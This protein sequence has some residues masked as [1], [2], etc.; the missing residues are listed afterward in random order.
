MFKRKIAIINEETGEIKV[1]DTVKQAIG[2]INRYIVEVDG[3]YG[4]IDEKG[5][6][7]C[8]IKYDEEI[9]NESKINFSKVKRRNDNHIE[10]K[11]RKFVMQVAK[12]GR[13]AIRCQTEEEAETL[14]SIFDSEGLKWCDKK[15]LIGRTRWERYGR[16]TCYTLVNHNVSYCDCMFYA[17]EGFEIM[18]F[19]QFL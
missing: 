14:L 2:N 16:E 1:Y 3:K 11:V 10:N 12:S 8:D 18:D 6:E 4:L 17:S 19:N 15:S 7:L 13:V 5:N 9:K